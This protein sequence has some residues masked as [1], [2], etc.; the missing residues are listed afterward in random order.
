MSNALILALQVIGFVVALI[1]VFVSHCHWY[2][3]IGFGVHVVGDYFRL[4]KDG[5]LNDLG[6]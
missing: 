2:Y 6:R 1:G 5:V 4:K 3:V